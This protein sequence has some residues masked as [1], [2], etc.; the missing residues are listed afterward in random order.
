[1]TRLEFTKAIK[2]A[3][4]SRAGG[5]CEHVDQD[6]DRCNKKLSPGDTEY[7]HV[8]PAALGGD[9]SLGNCAVLCRAHHS[10]KTTSTDVPRIAKAVR[11]H[12]RHIRGNGILFHGHPPA[13][14]G[15]FPS[16]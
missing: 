14:K 2:I 12:A 11:V 10:E 4:W 6:G 8:I 9:N 13:E 16:R 3:A 15:L 7:D 1:M 5:R